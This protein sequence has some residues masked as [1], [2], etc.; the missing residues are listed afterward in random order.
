MN[1]RRQSSDNQHL[2]P[3][4]LELGR[5]VSP[6]WSLRSKAGSTHSHDGGGLFSWARGE[7]KLR[8]G[9][10]RSAKAPVLPSV[11]Q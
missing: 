3:N 8:F 5:P 4:P 9:S 10:K 1:P 6:A 2:D 11:D 7:S